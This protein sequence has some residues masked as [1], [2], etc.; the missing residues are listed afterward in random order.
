MFKNNLIQMR[1]MRKMTQ[2]DVAEKVGVTRQAVAKW[3][4]GETL[5]DLDKCRILA[6]MF[7]VSLDDLANCRLNT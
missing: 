7:G 3:E 2:E 5:P 1:K 6:E 4:S